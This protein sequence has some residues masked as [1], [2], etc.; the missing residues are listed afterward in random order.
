[1]L[2]YDDYVAVFN[3]GDDATLVDRFFAE[4]VA[5]SGGTRDYRGKAALKAFLDWA[6]DGVREVL[7]P[8]NVLQRADLIFVEA[9]MD[10][11]AV[12]ERPDFPFGHL[13]PGDTLTVKFFVTYRLRAGKIVELKSMTWPPGKG[14]TNL[15]R[16]GGHASQLAAFRAYVAAFSNADFERFPRFYTEDVRLEL[17]SV[18]PLEGRQEVIDFYRARFRSVR[19]QLTIN[20][21]QA[22]DLAIELDA[23]DAEGP[24]LVSYQLRDGLICRIRVR[25]GAPTGPPVPAVAP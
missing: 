13:H 16:L 6:H 11:H 12:K 23:V 4:E 15:P 5:F 8:Q 20:T 24:I 17:Q 3:T 10:F 14:V 19:A 7:R 18:P 2:N 22:T 25:R 21:V 9:D 1:M